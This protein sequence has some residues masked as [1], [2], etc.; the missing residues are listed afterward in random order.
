[1]S[2]LPHRLAYNVSRIEPYGFIILIALLFSGVLGKLLWPLI[3][4]MMSLIAA[5]IGIPVAHL[6]KLANVI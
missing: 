6:L 3:G 5:L 4:M 2:L 1:M